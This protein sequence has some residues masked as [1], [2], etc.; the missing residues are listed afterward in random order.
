LVVCLG[1]LGF[2]FSALGHAE[3][4]LP[5]RAIAQ[6]SA[7][8]RASGGAL[9]ALLAGMRATAPFAI[10]VM[11]QMILYGVTALQAGLS[12]LMAQAMA[13]L[14]FSGAIL[15]AAQAL[16]AGTPVL[17]AGLMIVL[18]NARHILY[19]ARL[20][21]NLRRFRRPRRLLASYLLTDESFGADARR[22]R[23]GKYQQQ[24]W[25]FL[26]GAGLTMWLAVQGATALGLALGT[27]MQ[28]WDGL[29]FAPT[30]LF[31]CLAVL[32]LRGRASVAVALAA[33]IAAALLAGVPL[34]LGLFGAVGAGVI[35]GQL[36]AWR[37][38]RQS[39]GGGQRPQ[40]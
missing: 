38:K 23:E 36:A 3:R 5:H 39:R 12:P 19:S 29:R 9:S 17:V 26:V 10:G 33:G 2:S 22:A 11:P 30:L 40:P 18:L 7:R 14:V 35:A 1:G 20:A 34:G 6:P 24:W 31:V 13:L 37:G 25:W 27:Q 8:L 16:H 32:S 28:L 4:Y 21:P 15:P